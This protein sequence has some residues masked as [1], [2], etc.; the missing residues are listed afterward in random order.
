MA[1]TTK[2]P[3]ER[4]Q[5]I[6]VALELIESEGLEA[7]S[8]RKIAKRIDVNAASLYYHFKDKDDILKAAAS[9]AIRG[10]TYPEFDES[11]WTEWIVASAMAYHDYLNSRPRFVPLIASG[12]LSRSM[13]PMH[14]AV[15]SVLGSHKVS[16][17][18]QAQLFEAVEALVLGAA[19]MRSL[20]GVGGI[21][22]SD[23]AELQ[24]RQS[25]ENAIRLLVE[26][27]LHAEGTSTNAVRTGGTP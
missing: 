21:Y 23:R 5:V 25:I 20:N 18:T 19:M 26:G 17:G 1:R 8:V 15:A 2:P 9:Q 16:P 11:N 3:I 13:L 7:L 14:H 4:H 10:V 6:E 12:H 24:R 22:F 27:H